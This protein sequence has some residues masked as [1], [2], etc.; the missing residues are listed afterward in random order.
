EAGSFK[1][2]TIN[3]EPK[4]H[5]PLCGQRALFSDKEIAAAR[6]ET[7]ASAARIEADTRNRADVAPAIRAVMNGCHLCHPAA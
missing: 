4:V 5:V 3:F 1:R 6:G 7:A 2:K